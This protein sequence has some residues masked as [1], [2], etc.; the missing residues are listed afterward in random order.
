MAS[1]GGALQALSLCS[2]D[3]TASDALQGQRGAESRGAGGGGLGEGGRW[4]G[5]ERRGDT[6]RDSNTKRRNSLAFDFPLRTRQEAE[7]EAE[8]PSFS[9]GV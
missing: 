7:L 4:G 6:G 3:T 1:A 9:A 8:G 5:G 2:E